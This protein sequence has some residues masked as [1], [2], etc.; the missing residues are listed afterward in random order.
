MGPRD[1]DEGYGKIAHQAFW[2]SKDARTTLVQVDH[3]WEDLNTRDRQA[4]IAVGIAVR[5]TFRAACSV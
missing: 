1:Y 3:A 2:Q 5:D 4:W